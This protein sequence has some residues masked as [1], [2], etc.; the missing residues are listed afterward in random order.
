MVIIH[1]EADTYQ[2]WRKSYM[3]LEMYGN[4]SNLKYLA[5]ISQNWYRSKLQKVENA[6]G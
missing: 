6:V 5:S 3:V 4:E 1:E 2:N